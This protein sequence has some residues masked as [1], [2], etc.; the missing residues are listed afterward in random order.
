M[1][2]QNKA[3]KMRDYFAIIKEYQLKIDYHNIDEDEEEN[4]FDPYYSIFSNKIG[5][6]WYSGKTLENAI[7]DF[8]K[9]NNL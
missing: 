6:Y 4:E 2:P 5:G 7:D 8:I 9:E 3:T 1:F